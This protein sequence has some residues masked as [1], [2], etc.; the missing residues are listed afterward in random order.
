MMFITINV[1]IL[2]C[3]TVVMG[4]ALNVKRKRIVLRFIVTN[5]CD[6][7]VITF[8]GTARKSQSHSDFSVAPVLK[9]DAFDV[10]D[11][12]VELRR[13]SRVI[14]HTENRTVRTSLEPRR[15]RHAVRGIFPQ[16][17]DAKNRAQVRFSRSRQPALRAFVRN[18]QV[19]IAQLTTSSR[20][21]ICA[22]RKK[23][24]LSRQLCVRLEDKASGASF[25]SVA[26]NARMYNYRR[27]HR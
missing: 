25:A 26:C 15:K 20:H 21:L 9:V 10:A 17:P 1:K 8:N 5:I 14:M 23:F 19:S 22:A 13:E 12:L 16:S 6:C 18:G 24:N 4:L 7:N 27:V 2:F 3:V 11:A